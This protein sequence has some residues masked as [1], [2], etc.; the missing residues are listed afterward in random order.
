MVWHPSQD[1]RTWTPCTISD[2]TR[3][4][5]IKLLQNVG[6]IYWQIFELFAL[7]RSQHPTP[8]PLQWPPRTRTHRKSKSHNWRCTAPPPPAF[9]ELNSV[10]NHFVWFSMLNHYAKFCYL[11][12]TTDSVMLNYRT[13]ININALISIHSIYDDMASGWHGK[14]S[15][16]MMLL[17]VLNALGTCNTAY[18][19][20]SKMIPWYSRP[21][22]FVNQS[23]MLTNMAHMR[24]RLS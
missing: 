19:I 9:R 23:D 18:A 15:S 2:Y 21:A 6:I 22:C 8:I 4:I 3:D 10:Q 20:P 5:V 14:T 13:Q 1:N 7:V 16:L 11:S 17:T 12:V 24:Y